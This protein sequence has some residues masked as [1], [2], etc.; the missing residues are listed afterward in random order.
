MYLPEAKP[1]E[2]LED[3]AYLTGMTIQQL[4]DA[5]VN[6]KRHKQLNNLTILELENQININL[7]HVA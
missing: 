1:H 6:K 2:K 5:D 3:I 7:K 4:M